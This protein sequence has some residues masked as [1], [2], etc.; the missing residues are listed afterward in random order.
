MGGG[1][2]TSGAYQQ[3]PHDGMGGYP[4]QNGSHSSMQGGSHQDINRHGKCC[5]RGDT[6]WHSTMFLAFLNGEF[7]RIFI[8]PA[9]ENVYDEAQWQ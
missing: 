8:W 7:C 5:Q 4:P 2:M 6:K 1:M 9:V 3:D